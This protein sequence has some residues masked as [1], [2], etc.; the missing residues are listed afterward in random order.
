M[1][2]WWW[3][4]VCFCLTSCANK[5]GDHPPEPT[6]GQVLVNGQPANAAMVVFY[7]QGDWGEKSIVPQ[8]LTD[9]D[10]R[11]VLS[12]YTMQ[13]GAPAGE[14]RVTVEWPTSLGKNPG[15]DKLGGKY[16]KRETSGLTARIEKGNNVLPAFDLRANLVKVPDNPKT[17]RSRR[18]DR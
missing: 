7:H 9:D 11:F 10:G 1:R 12:T 8:A 3:F 18:Q 13:D 5:Y 6:S 17:M 14:Y 15:P 4:C 16:A 2:H